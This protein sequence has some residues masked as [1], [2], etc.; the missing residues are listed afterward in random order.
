MSDEIDQLS[1]TL[2]S[3]GRRLLAKFKEREEDVLPLLEEYVDLFDTWERVWLADQ[4]GDTKHRKV[5]ESILNLHGEIIS[6]ARSLSEDTEN[7]LKGIRGWS[8]GIRAYIDHFPSKISTRR[9]KKG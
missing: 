3:L 8:K 1:D 2:S 7:S 5:G 4:G 6:V 9:G